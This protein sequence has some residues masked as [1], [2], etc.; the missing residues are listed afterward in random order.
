[1][2]IIVSQV[3]QYTDAYS[4]RTEESSQKQQYNIYIYIYISE[5]SELP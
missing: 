2:K 4:S 5:N 3:V 1:M